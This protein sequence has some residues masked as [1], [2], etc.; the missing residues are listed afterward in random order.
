MKV[1][2]DVTQYENA[3]KGDILFYNGTNWV[4]QNKISFLAQT[5]KECVDL[6]EEIQKVKKDTTTLLEDYRNCIKLLHDRVLS[7]EHEI[8]VLKGEE[9][10]NE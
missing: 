10:E 4:L 8:R 7:M 5:G 3:Q 6:K 9:D 1:I 2:I